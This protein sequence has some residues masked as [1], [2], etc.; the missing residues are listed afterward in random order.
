MERVGTPAALS[1]RTLLRA[2]ATLSLVGG[3]VSACAGR[4]LEPVV[5]GA[6][7]PSADVPLPALPTDPASGIPGLSQL[8][9][10]I[11]EFFRIDVAEEMPIP[12]TDAW[13]LTIDGLVR[14]P[15]TLTY[16]QL[17]ERDLIEVDATIVCVSNAV[18]GFLVG[19]AR[20]LGV[21]LDDLIAEA[22]PLSRADEV[23]GHSVDGFT[24]GF[25][26]SVLDG[27]DA[28]VAIGMNGEPLQPKHGYPA[29]IIVPGLYGYVSAVKW[30][31]RIELTRFDEQVGYWIP[32]GWAERAPVKLASR[33]DAPRPMQTLNPGPNTL[34]GVAWSALSGIAKVEVSVD[35]GAWQEAELGPQLSA[36]TWRQWWLPWTAETGTHRVVVRAWDGEGNVQ[37]RREVPPLPNGAEGLHAITVTVA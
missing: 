25:P 15:I 19:N 24:A 7:L 1:R 18:G 2:F 33:I 12:S 22:G 10:P 8:T 6:V 31:Q 37:S 20:W 16:A 5:R 32:R 17:I 14:T 3:A 13:T 28:I 35:D 21:R 34:G 26:L 36:S 23:M 30:L 9:T 29:R 27:R 11:E 4:T